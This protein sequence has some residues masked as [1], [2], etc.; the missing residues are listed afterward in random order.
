M[1]VSVTGL[2]SAGSWCPTPRLDRVHLSENFGSFD[3]AFSTG[4]D[5]VLVTGVGKS[6]MVIGA[7]SWAMR[8]MRTCDRSRQKLPERYEDREGGCLLGKEGNRDL[9]RSRLIRYTT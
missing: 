7:L 8:M 2:P 6:K 5:H 3:G 9:R 4:T 1:G